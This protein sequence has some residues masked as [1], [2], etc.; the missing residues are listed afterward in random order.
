[1]TVHGI[2]YKNIFKDVLELFKSYSFLLERRD[3]T[4]ILE[5]GFGLSEKS[6]L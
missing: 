2:Y 1:M 5:Q 4:I 3:R 6:L